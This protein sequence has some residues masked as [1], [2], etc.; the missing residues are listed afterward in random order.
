MQHIITQDF[1]RNKDPPPV[2]SSASAAFQSVVPPVSSS[3]RG[4]MPSRYSPENQVQAQHH[5]RPSSRV[6]PENASDKPRA[7]YWMPEL[8]RMKPIYFLPS[9]KNLLS[10]SSSGLASLQSEEAGRWRTM[11]PS[12]HHRATKAWTNRSQVDLHPS[13]ER[14]TA[15]RLGTG[16]AQLVCLIIWFYN[17]SD[18]VL[19]FLKVCV[20]V[21]SDSL[22]LFLVQGVTHGPQGVLAIC[23]PSSPSWRTPH[24]WWNRRSRRSF[25]SW[26]PPLVLVI[27]MLVSGY[28]LILR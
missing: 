24:Q 11:N 3:G 27:L 8:I 6:S 18:L 4:K 7:R 21:L 19:M 25:V 22:C 23:L 10:F 13:G 26:T 14:V 16:A 15:Q 12:L 5:Q 9:D 1:A 20:T 2:S 28:S 17:D